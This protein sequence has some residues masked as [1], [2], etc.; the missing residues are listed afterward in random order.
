MGRDEK[1]I[2]DLSMSM[3]VQFLLSTTPFCYE[4]PCAF[5]SD[6]ISYSLRIDPILLKDRIKQG[7]HILTTLIK[8]KCLDMVT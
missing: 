8:L 2:L 6:M 1:L 3:N 4:V 5:N 7:G